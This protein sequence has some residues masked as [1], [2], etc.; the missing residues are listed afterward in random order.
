MAVLDP[1]PFFKDRHIQTQKIGPE[2]FLCF[3]P[4]LKLLP[5]QLRTIQ[6]IL[7][8]FQKTTTLIVLFPMHVRFFSFLC[9]HF[10]IMSMYFMS[11]PPPFASN[12]PCF[13]VYWRFNDPFHILG[14][15]VYFQISMKRKCHDLNS[16]YPSNKCYQS[17]SLFLPF[18]RIFWI[19]FVYIFVNIYVHLVVHGV[20]SA[21]LQCIWSHYKGTNNK[22]Q[23]EWVQNSLL[24]LEFFL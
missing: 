10:V 11:P 5:T 19:E 23:G 6:R 16:T 17:F 2:A 13:A 7:F 21:N 3:S 8:V 4:T 9:S 15:T 12:L 24:I 20:L 1:P 18:V 22:T 14:N